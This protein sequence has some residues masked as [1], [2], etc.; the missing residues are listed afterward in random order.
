MVDGV[1]VMILAK[2]M[3]MLLIFASVER[4]GVFMSVVF[5]YAGG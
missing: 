5:A 2:F 4:I 1:S 3:K